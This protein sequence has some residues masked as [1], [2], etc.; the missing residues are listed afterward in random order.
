RRRLLP[1]RRPRR[2][3]G[4]PSGLGQLVPRLTGRTGRG[5]GTGRGLRPGQR[6]QVLTA[7]SRCRLRRR[8]G[9]SGADRRVP[10]GAGPVVSP[11]S[12][13]RWPPPEACPVATPGSLARVSQTHAA[14]EPDSPPQLTLPEESE[15]WR[16]AYTWVRSDDGGGCH[17]WP[18]APGRG[19]RARAPDP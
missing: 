15:Y 10:G 12:F 1:L 19:R 9:G 5:S 16:G 14:L 11:G 18:L 7:L 2:Y 13:A 4:S 3:A 6:E 8:R 17:P